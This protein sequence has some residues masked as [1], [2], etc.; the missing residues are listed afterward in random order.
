MMGLYVYYDPSRDLGGRVENLD[1]LDVAPTLLKAMGLRVPED[2]CSPQ[3]RV[4][5]ALIGRTRVYTR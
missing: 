1:I 5:D 3:G 2:M 4:D